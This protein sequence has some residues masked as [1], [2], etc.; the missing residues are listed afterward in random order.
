MKKCIALLL[1]AFSVNSAY[2]KP[3]CENILTNAD[4]NKSG[5]S[6]F[7]SL[8]GSSNNKATAR[9]DCES[10]TIK[11]TAAEIE[12]I[13]NKI[14][15]VMAEQHQLGL[16]F[17]T[18]KEDT[19]NVIGR[20]EQLIIG[21]DKELNRFKGTAKELLQL[22]G[23]IKDFEISNRQKTVALEKQQD[24][25]K[26]LIVAN[27]QK[28]NQYFE[29]VGNRI[30]V[31]SSNLN[32]TENNLVEKLN[33]DNQAINQNVEAFYTKVSGK[34]LYLVV[35][36]AALLLIFSLVFYLLRKK[37]A[38]QGEISTSGL[39]DIRKSLEEDFVK[40]DS[41]LVE[42]FEAQMLGI[43]KNSVHSESEVD[44]GFIIKVADEIVRIQKNISRMDEKTKGLK[45]LSASVTRIQDNVASNGYEIV[46]ML[47]MPYSKGMKAV[48]D[49]IIDENLET[50]EQIITRVI[51]PQINYQGVM[52]QSA[53]IE[54]SQGE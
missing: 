20:L 38:N 41:K 30:D 48:V 45:Q 46:E 11:N 1:F 5:Q 3:N 9:A 12:L 37:L 47:G 8:F 44:H 54:V 10:E 50:G 39:L 7:S 21:H 14:K 13:D 23:Q 43:E 53:Q 17:E 51:K 4:D 34:V 28:M 40:I 18:N 25:N 35:A 26:A 22:K 49:F 2:S 32:S 15:L 33:N 6:F 27:E 36:I 31:L 42:I 24:I 19:N 29:G 16:D 52:I